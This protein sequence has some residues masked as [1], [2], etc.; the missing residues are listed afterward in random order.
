MGSTDGAF[1]GLDPG[2]PNFRDLVGYDDSIT[3]DLLVALCNTGRAV[4]AVGN[5][6]GT[7]KITLLCGT[8]TFIIGHER[9]R[10]IIDENWSRT[11]A[12]FYEAG[13]I[14]GPRLSFDRKAG[15]GGYRIWSPQRLL[16]EIAGFIGETVQDSQ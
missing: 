8:P 11:K 2:R 13:S 14:F 9:K 15:I 12:G 3:L 4:A 5:Q 6:S 10:H 16:R 1:N 7:V